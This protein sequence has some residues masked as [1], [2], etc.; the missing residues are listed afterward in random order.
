V[1][2]PEPRAI[3]RPPRFLA[4]ENLEGAIVHGARRKR[5]GMVF[6]T[7]SEAG[8]RHLDDPDVLRRARELDLILITHDRKTMPHHFAE[9]LM[10][11]QEGEHCPGIFILT[12]KRYSIGQIIEFIVE[13]YDLSSHDEW[14]D[15]IGALPL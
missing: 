12:Q 14:R 9:L 4:D 3:P 15:Q 10:R 8:T 2:E 6:L 11:L 5:P 1:S 7:A 13:L